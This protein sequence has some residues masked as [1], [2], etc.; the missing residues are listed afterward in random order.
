M[1]WEAKWQ[2]AQAQSAAAKSKMIGC[3]VGATQAAHEHLTTQPPIWWV[4]GDDLVWKS[5]E[6]NL[7]TFTMD[8]LNKMLE[9]VGA[10]MGASTHISTF[11]HTST[12][13]PTD[14]LCR[15]VPNLRGPTV[16]CPGCCEQSSLAFIIPHIND[17][18]KWTRERIADW[19][20][21]LDIDLT[22]KPMAESRNFTP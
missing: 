18:H 3:D 19:L 15:I 21:T 12:F 4:H 14:E 17:E 9:H 5:M 10:A 1:K 20:D 22:V 16:Q 8:A 13:M 7:A 11:T 6:D 2:D